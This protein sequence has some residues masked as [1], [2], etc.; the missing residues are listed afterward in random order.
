VG[1]GKKLTRAILAWAYDYA[2]LSRADYEAFL[3]SFVTPQD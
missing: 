3:A 1:G 2:R